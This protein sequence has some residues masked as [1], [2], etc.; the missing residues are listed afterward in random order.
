MMKCFRNI[1][2]TYGKMLLY[3]NSSNLKKCLRRILH[4]RKFLTAIKSDSLI[5]E[6]SIWQVLSS[7]SISSLEVVQAL[8]LQPLSSQW[9]S[10]S[11]NQIFC[12]LLFI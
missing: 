11:N 4:H 7:S 1:L 8:L 2:I 5:E 10:E 9:Q 3:R 6:D 12:K